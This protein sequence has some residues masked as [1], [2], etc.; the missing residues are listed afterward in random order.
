M[1]IKK[2][3][4]VDDSE[5]KVELAMWKKSADVQ[6]DKGDILFIKN[7]TVS[8]FHGRN[9]SASDNTKISINPQALKEALLL[10][11]WRANFLGEFKGYS[12]AE[13]LDKEKGE[14]SEEVDKKCILRMGDCLDRYDSGNFQFKMNKT[15]EFS[16]NYTIKA[17]VNYLSHS[18]KN[19]YAGCPSK[20]CK[21]KLVEDNNIFVC[22]GCRL[23]VKIPAYYLILSVRI[24]DVSKEQW[25]DLY[26]STAEKFLGTT[27][28]EYREYLMTNNKSKL[29]EISKRVEFNTFYFL[30]RVKVMMYNSMLK[31][32]INVY[33]TEKLEV[34]EESKRLLQVLLNEQ[35]NIMSHQMQKNFNP[36]NSEVSSKRNE[37]NC[38]FGIKDGE[39]FTF[40]SRVNDENVNNINKRKFSNHNN[41]HNINSIS[42]SSNNDLEINNYNEKQVDENNN[43]VY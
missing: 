27:A 36:L 16:E 34:V 26:G 9:I 43:G 32:K 8:E 21:K 14:Y 15:E 23:T 18:E 22:P 35:E 41:S 42:S 10:S 1:A 19:I 37:N 38:S 5:F 6:I 12:P 17:I 4:I 25:V 31:K 11:K 13:K 40:S 29:N 24:K 7:A 2:V 39:T 28:E 3:F 20:K 33:N 30:I